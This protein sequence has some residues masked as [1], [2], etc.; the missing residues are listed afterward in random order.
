MQSR[1]SEV[2][3]QHL[4]IIVNPG[5]KIPVGLYVPDDIR[6]EGVTVYW[7]GAVGKDHLVATLRMAEREWRSKNGG[8]KETLYIYGATKE[9]LKFPKRDVPEGSSVLT[10]KNFD[11]CR[12]E[13]CSGTGK[14]VLWANVTPSGAEESLERY[15]E[16]I[17][18]AFPPDKFNSHARPIVAYAIQ[19]T[20]SV[21]KS[22]ADRITGLVYKRL[23]TA[24]IFA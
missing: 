21:S 15:A 9:I 24:P 6:N 11:A 2:P 23:H 19:Q 5:D 20:M 17:G 3:A 10:H 12:V 22:D 16:N 18:V 7:H 13:L 4:D 14:L 8:P 1:K